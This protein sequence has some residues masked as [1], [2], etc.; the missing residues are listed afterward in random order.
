M[1]CDYVK[2]ESLKS[3][4][5]ASCARCGYVKVYVDYAEFLTATSV[6]SN[7]FAYCPKCTQELMKGTA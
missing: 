3:H 6:W 7:G 2:E 1:I 4:W 5:T